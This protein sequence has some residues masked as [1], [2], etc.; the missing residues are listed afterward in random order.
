[1]ST[2]TRAR[3]RMS[4]RRF[5]RL[6]C[7]V[8]RERDFKLVGERMLDLSTDGALIEVSRPVLTGE[9]ILLSFRAPRSDLWFDVEATVARVV[10]GRRDGDPGLAVG[11]EFHTLDQG[12]RWELWSSLRFLAPPLPT[13]DPRCLS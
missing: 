3:Q 9:R 6:P 10:H 13:R 11:L 8:V 12:S 1:M 4:F 5:V 2:L 7:Q